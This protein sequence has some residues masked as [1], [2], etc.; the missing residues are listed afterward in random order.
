MLVR[1]IRIVNKIK[2]LKIMT[3]INQDTLA[4]FAEI[5]QNNTKEWF[6]ENKKRWES[7]KTNHALFME[8]LQSKVLEIE[9]IIPKEGKKYVSRI[10]RDF[11]FTQDKSPY[12]NHIFS[13]IDRHVDETK[14]RFYIQLQPQGSFVATG[15]WQPDSKTLKKV[16]QEIDFNSSEFNQIINNPSFKGLFGEVD[17][18]KLVRPPQGYSVDNENIEL[19]KL[20]QYVIRRSF[21]DEEVLSENLITK[22]TETYQE[23]LAFMQFFDVA[24]AE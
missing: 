17:G 20:K 5:Q 2:N 13:L 9:Q 15:V 4:F 12:R 23:A 16:R 10:N 19:L 7:I 22:I 8:E 1:L 14:P 6:E 24:V 18:E 21:S 3:T 11:R